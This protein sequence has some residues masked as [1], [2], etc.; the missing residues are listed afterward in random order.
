MILPDYNCLFIHIPKTGGQSITHFFLDHMNL[1]WEDRHLFLVKPNHDPEKG[2][3][4]LTHLTAN[5]YLRFGH[6]D[7]NTFSSYFKFAI[8]RNPWS[9]LVS[10]YI[11]NHLGHY[12]F[13]DFILKN[14]P[15]KESDCYHTPSAPYR[16]VLPQSEYILNE[17]GK[18]LVDFVGHFETLE[19][20][21]STV[22]KA[23]GLSSRI[24]LRNLNSATHMLKAS[25]IQAGVMS[26]AQSFSL[27]NRYDYRTFYDADTR[28]FVAD[29]YAKDIELLGYRFEEEATDRPI[30]L[31][32]DSHDS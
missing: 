21:M 25:F 20:D 12:S 17:Q 15:T 18:L 24:R 6:L 2:P 13:R 28:Q 9:R 8:V 22:G 10:E 29:R 1:S 16:H 4:R 32:G 14:F 19:R 3:P 30:K 31:R 26:A 27:K 5:E 11:F 7:I 23:L